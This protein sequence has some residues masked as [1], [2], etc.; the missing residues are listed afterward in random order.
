M[1]F[2][3]QEVEIE[4]V[5]CLVILEKTILE[6]NDKDQE[7]EQSQDQ[8][9]AQEKIQDLNEKTPIDHRD[10]LKEWRITKEHPIHNVIGDT[11][12]WVTIWDSLNKL[13]NFVVFID[14]KYI[15]KSYFG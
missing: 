8:V 3:A 13:C 1:F 5:D 2:G 4:V 6:E 14:L 11:S 9:P 7:V 12:K 10:L 15:L